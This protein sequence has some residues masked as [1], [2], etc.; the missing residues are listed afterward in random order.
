MPIIE[1]GC[2]LLLGYSLLYKEYDL[3][4]FSHPKE[5]YSGGFRV[6]IL[7]LHTG[8]NGALGHGIDA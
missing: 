5:H 6:F 2:I 1:L 4:M 8:A 3:I 7:R